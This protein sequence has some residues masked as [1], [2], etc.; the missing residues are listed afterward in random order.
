ME[1]IIFVHQAND[2]TGSTRVLKDVIE[3]EYCN[4]NKLVLTINEE[5]GILS[6]LDNVKIFNIWTPR[7][8]GKRI[9]I[10]STTISYIHR[11]F[12]LLFYAKGID[13]FM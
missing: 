11:V 12:L 5:N 8:N 7:L 6:S 2:Y 13:I 9:P 1:S 4:F 3:S 10:L